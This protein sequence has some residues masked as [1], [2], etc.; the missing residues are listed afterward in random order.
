M[1]VFLSWAL[2]LAS[3]ALGLAAGVSVMTQQVLN[4]NL[5]GALNSAAWAGFASYFVGL[6]SMG[7]LVLALR[8]P[9]PAL[10]VAA[11]VPWYVWSGGLFGA[12]FIA[13]SIFL[14]PRIGAAAFIALLVA[15]R[16]SARWPSTISACS[17]SSGASST[18]RAWSARRCSSRGSC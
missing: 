4:A 3:W 11:R 10:A 17:A 2:G 14:V 12:I 1:Q 5:R 18:C 15:G 7:L 13:L 9:V 8:E 6:A 16:C